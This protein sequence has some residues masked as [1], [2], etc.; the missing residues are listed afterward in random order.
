M[1]VP[2]IG[3][4]TLPLPGHVIHS[5]PPV[6]EPCRDE[7]KVR[8]AVEVGDGGERGR[9]VVLER[10]HQPFG[11]AADGAGYVKARDDIIRG[12]GCNGDE[13]SCRYR[14]AGDVPGNSAARPSSF[15]LK[16]RATRQYLPRITGSRE[17]KER[18]R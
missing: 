8:Q 1:P 12:G 17:S 6:G 16:H 7:Q 18:A 14:Q 9:G 4:D 13:T 10:D 11:A 15:T 5:R 2:R 3:T